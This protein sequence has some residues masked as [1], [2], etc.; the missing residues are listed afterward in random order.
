[1]YTTT[2][3]TTKGNSNNDAGNDA[4]SF[5]VTPTH[6]MEVR[7]ITYRTI[8]DPTLWDTPFGSGTIQIQGIYRTG[9]LRR[10]HVHKL[11]FGQ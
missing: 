5:E 10:M 9:E 3:S 11:F 7:V 4:D 2:P 8:I 6:C 1:M